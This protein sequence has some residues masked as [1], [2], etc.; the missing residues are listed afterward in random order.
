MRA[1]PGE[2]RHREVGFGA[3]GF[4]G[5][6]SFF[7]AIRD[8]SSPPP[9]LSPPPSITL[10]PGVFVT[11]GS[12]AGESIASQG[13]AIAPDPPGP[14]TEA[15]SPPPPPPKSAPPTPRRTV[16]AAN[17]PTAAT[18]TAAPRPAATPVTAAEDGARPG[19]VGTPTVLETTSSALRGA[20]LEKGACVW[21]KPPPPIFSSLSDEDERVPD[22]YPNAV[23]P[24]NRSSPP[25]T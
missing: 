24:P 17:A 12:V 15:S 5:P 16:A 2:G 4:G 9:P 20:S 7:G 14:V 22:V 23:A 25:R 3:F 11:F 6:R 19:E 18:P 8:A 13:E 21:R 10:N 1:I